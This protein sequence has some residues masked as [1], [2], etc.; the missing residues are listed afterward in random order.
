M[1]EEKKES[2]EEAKKGFEDEVREEFHN[3]GRKVKYMAASNIITL[4]VVVLLLT[5]Q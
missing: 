5:R 3:L 2:E 1:E 4:L